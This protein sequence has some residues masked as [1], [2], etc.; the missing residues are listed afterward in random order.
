MECQGRS[1]WQ[2]KSC[3]CWW[4]SWSSPM[5]LMHFLWGPCSPG[6]VLGRFCSWRDRRGIIG[7]GFKERLAFEGAWLISICCCPLWKKG[8]F[9]FKYILKVQNIAQGRCSKVIYE[10]Y[11]VDKGKTDLKFAYVEMGLRFFRILLNLFNQQTFQSLFPFSLYLY[12]LHILRYL[13]T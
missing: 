5:V 8:I 11:R 2:G 12:F 4:P 3:C 7:D 13:N 9:D 6:V 10:R 1:Y